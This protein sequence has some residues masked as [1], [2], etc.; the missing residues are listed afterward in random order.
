MNKD[1]GPNLKCCEGSRS[2][3]L[4]GG[5]SLSSNLCCSHL[6][7]GQLEGSFYQ[8]SPPEPRGMAFLSQ[9]LQSPMSESSTLGVD[10][11]ASKFSYKLH[12]CG[13]DQGS[14]SSGSSMDTI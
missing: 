1:Q 5:I 13:L 7:K 4:L 9:H 8:L 14:S 3:H 6:G 2:D 11:L 10:I 12:I